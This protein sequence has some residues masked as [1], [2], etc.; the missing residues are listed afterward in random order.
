MVEYENGAIL[1]YSLCVFG[2]RSSDELLIGT[3]GT[4]TTTASKPRVTPVLR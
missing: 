1:N 2:D 4:I 3:H